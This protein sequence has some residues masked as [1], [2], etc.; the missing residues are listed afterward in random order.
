MAS[1]FELG[2]SI[3]LVI[4]N[5]CYI[6]GDCGAIKRVITNLVQNAIEHGGKN[7]TIRV[8]KTGFEVDDDGPGIPLEARERVFEP[9]HR[10]RPRNTG[11]G[12]GLNLVQEIIKKHQGHVSIHTSQRGGALLRVE[13]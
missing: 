10:L 4:S 3:E 8:L 13:F 5:N 11:S 1:S 6:T 2:C 9:F 12:L 7:I